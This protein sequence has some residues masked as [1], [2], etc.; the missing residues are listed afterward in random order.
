MGGY[1]KVDEPK[2]RQTL[3]VEEPLFLVCL[4]R[5]RIL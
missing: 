1:R 5:G 3:K 2:K 4:D